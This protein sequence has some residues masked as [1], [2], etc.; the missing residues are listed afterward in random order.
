MLGTTYY[1]PPRAS[2][3]HLTVSPG[4]LPW[5]FP[6]SASG[7]PRSQRLLDFYFHPI[8]I[9]PLACLGLPSQALSASACICDPPE[10]QPSLT[11]TSGVVSSQVLL[12]LVLLEQTAPASSAWPL[13]AAL[14]PLV[15]MCMCV[16]ACTCACMRVYVHVADR[17]QLHHLTILSFLLHPVLCSSGL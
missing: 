15:C 5:L 3:S 4:S 13:S 9:Y 1:P 8:A 6:M 10:P 7:V 14:F 12:C 17:G 16:C 11:S 2:S